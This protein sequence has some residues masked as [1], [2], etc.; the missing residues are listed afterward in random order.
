MFAVNY[1]LFQESFKP[2]HNDG[3]NIGNNIS[4]RISDK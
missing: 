1:L 4:S 3:N 2:M